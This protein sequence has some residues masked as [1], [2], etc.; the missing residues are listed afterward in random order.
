M[1]VSVSD[2]VEEYLTH[3]PLHEDPW[4]GSI[5]QLDGHGHG[6]GGTDGDS[7]THVT[8]RTACGP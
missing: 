7:C 3:I 1:F 2:Q 5:I 6:E 8:V 4:T